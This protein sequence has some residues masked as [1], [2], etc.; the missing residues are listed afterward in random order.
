MMTFRNCPPLNILLAVDGSAHA[1]A[2]VQLL[3][4]LPLPSSSQV[5]AVGVVT[6]RHT[7]GQEALST[8]LIETQMILGGTGVRVTT[9]LLY[10]HPAQALTDFAEA[11]QPALIVVGAKGLRATLGILLGGV[12]QQVVEYGRQPVLVVRAPYQALRHVLLVTDG[13]AP[14]QHAVN[15][16]ARFPLPAGAKTWVMH[17][18]PPRPDPETLV[19]E[20]RE[21]MTRVV[22]YEQHEGQIM[23]E[24]ATQKLQTA[25][26]QAE[27]ILA[28][29]DA[30]TEIIEYAKEH[31]IDLVVSGSRG[32]SQVKGWYLGSVS[33]KLVHYAHCSVLIV[34]DNAP[35]E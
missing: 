30:A 12:A 28:H 24:Q 26:L 31:S 34:K 1:R 9:E 13:S 18:L 32:L 16:L 6:P 27:P 8:A 14:S 15:Y 4:G 29:G 22:E 23:V 10:G 17:V 2:A 20:A 33:R 7:P 3:G 21:I 35:L 11:H 19:P 25:Q 5:T